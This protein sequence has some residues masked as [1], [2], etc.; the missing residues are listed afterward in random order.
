MPKIRLQIKELKLIRSI[1]SLKKGKTTWYTR[2]CLAVHIMTKSPLYKWAGLYYHT[3]GLGPW[4]YYD[5]ILHFN[6]PPQIDAGNQ[7]AT[8][9]EPGI[10]AAAV[11]GPW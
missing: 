8:I 1:R 9:C 3:S 7:P 11:E 2:F 6:T 5:T 4:A 10:H